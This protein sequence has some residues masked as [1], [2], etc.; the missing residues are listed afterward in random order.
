MSITAPLFLRT[1]WK[2]TIISKMQ[3]AGRLLNG[4]A[5][6]G[7]VNGLK[8]VFPIIGSAPRPVVLTKSLQPVQPANI[9]TSTVEVDLVDRELADYV[10]APDLEKMGGSLKDAKQNQIAMSFGREHD[11]ILLEAASAFVELNTGKMQRGDGTTAIDLLDTM[12]MKAE[13]AGT[14][15]GENGNIYCAITHKDFGRF[16]LVKEFAS[17]DWV[18]DNN[19]PLSGMATTKRTYNGVHYLALPD[20]YFTTLAP[21][22]DK[23]YSFMWH[24]EAVGV[25]A[26]IMDGPLTVVQVETLQGSPWLI[27]DFMSTAAVGI[28]DDGVRRFWNTKTTAITRPA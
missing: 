21:A 16:N 24:R 4:M 5:M 14:G 26:N 19:L 18:G 22:A 13:I 15:S 25:E 6:R 17:S 7:D 23:T 11:L 3:S 10:Y 12:D 9:G 1:L 2:S 20:A 8:V 28:H 27:K